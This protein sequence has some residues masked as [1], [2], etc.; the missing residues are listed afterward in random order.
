MAE[1][2]PTK[3]AHA[4]DAIRRAVV[5]G[6]I[7]PGD[8]VL[9]ADWAHRLGL[10]PTPVREALQQ[11]EALGVVVITPH[12][13]ARVRQR[14]RR[15]FEKEARIRTALEQ[16]VVDMLLEMNDAELAL[17]TAAA[18]GHAERFAAASVA[19]DRAVS[20]E[21]NDAFHQTL[22]EATA[23]PKLLELMASM[24]GAYS[25]YAYQ[26]TPAAM[27]QGADE[28]LALVLALERRDPE[29]A[30]RTVSAHIESAVAHVPDSVGGTALF[31]DAADQA[32]AWR[33]RRTAAARPARVRTVAP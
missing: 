9:V 18:R 22:Y 32:R 29:S 11:L 4:A 7:R 17:V 5:S 25:F 3:T 31:T 14:S 28:H 27:R 20:F 10:S 33:P 12:Q 24:R 16:L 30:H 1:L 19:G 26:L 23:V 13:G 21:S 15:E 8:R 6:E 2:F